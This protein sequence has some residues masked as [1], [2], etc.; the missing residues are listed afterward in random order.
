MEWKLYIIENFIHIQEEVS[1]F[2][3]FKDFEVMHLD[4]E[5]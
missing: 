1:R 5:P 2:V 3:I 4:S